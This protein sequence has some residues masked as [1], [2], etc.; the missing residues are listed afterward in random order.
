MATPTL[1]ISRTQFTVGDFVSWMRSGELDLTPSFQR[2]HVW[3]KSAKSYLIDT[4][5]RGLPTPIIFLRQITDTKK[6]TTK[7]QVVDGQQR[8]RTLLAFIDKNLLKDF[9]PARDDFTV[10][11]THN[12]DIADTAFD[13]LNKE[14]RQRILDYQIS[15]HVLPNDTSDQ[16]VLDIFRRMNA[17]GTKLN[18]QELRNAAHFGLFIKSVYEISYASLDLWRNWKAFTEDNIARMEEAE[19]VSELYIMMLDGISEKSQD[20]INKAYGKYDKT[21]PERAQLEKRLNAI[22]ADLDDEYGEEMPKSPLRNRIVLYALIAAVYR[23]SYGNAD[24][25]KNTAKKKI[26]SFDRKL[27][28]IAA[29]LEKDKRDQLP[30]GVQEALL[31][32]PGRKS[33]REALTDYIAKRL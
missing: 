6:L 19:F 7:R 29:L 24:L 18:N 8:I 32:R 26:V 10:T 28:K 22:L 17:T 3:K 4:I 21:F 15:T 5:V 12:A 23:L 33:N 31:S 1:N 11:E 20:L 13:K 16:Q 2:R 25:K 14:Y 27:A 30:E 9:D